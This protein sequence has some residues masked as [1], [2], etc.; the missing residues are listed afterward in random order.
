MGQVERETMW[1]ASLLW[2]HVGEFAPFLGV[3]GINS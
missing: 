2:C 1:K 3:S